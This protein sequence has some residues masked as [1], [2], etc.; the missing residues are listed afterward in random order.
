[1][2]YRIFSTSE[3][4]YFQ[5]KSFLSVRHGPFTTRKEAKE[6]AEAYVKDW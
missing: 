1:M 4:F 6:A 3:G 2:T 5:T